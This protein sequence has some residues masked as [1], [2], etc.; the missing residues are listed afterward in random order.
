M[1]WT[2]ALLG[3]DRSSKRGT[4]E[5]SFTRKSKGPKEDSFKRKSKAAPGEKPRPL[6]SRLKR[7][8]T[9]SWL[10]S[11]APKSVQTTKKVYPSFHPSNYSEE[12]DIFETT[13]RA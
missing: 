13:R 7:K 3:G 1:P 11:W 12:S 9:S 10:L 8:G 6:L 2:D 5:H 4:K